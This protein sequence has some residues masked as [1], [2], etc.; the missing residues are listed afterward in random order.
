M[1][2]R[3]PPCTEPP[4][5]GI[6][7]AFEKLIQTGIMKV[8][9]TDTIHFTVSTSR[10]QQHVHRQLRRCIVQ[11][12]PVFQVHVCAV[13]HLVGHRQPTDTVRQQ[14]LLILIAARTRLPAT[15]TLTLSSTFVTR[16][17]SSSSLNTNTIQLALPPVLNFPGCPGFVPCCPASRQDKP[18]DAKC[19]GFQG[20]VKMTKIIITRRRPNGM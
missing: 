10:Q 20:K 18:R 5:I 2:L 6:C 8:A 13:H 1:A 3:L 16:T 7:N 17:T 4:H 14:L 9:N 15:G 12:M 19:P 11:P